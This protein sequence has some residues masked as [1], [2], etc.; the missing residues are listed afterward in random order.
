MKKALSIALILSMVIIVFAGCAPDSP[1][2]S[3]G[4]TSSGASSQPAPS[5]EE[6]S[7]VY[8]L[9]IG[10]AQPETNPRHISLLAFKEMVEDKTNGGIIVEIFPAGQLGNEKEM[11]EAVKM[12]TLQGMRG[13]HFEYLQKALIF[14]LPFLCENAKQVEALMNSDFALEI[15]EPAK[16]HGLIVLGIGD[17]GGFRHFSNNVRQIKNLRTLPV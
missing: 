7:K 14:T 16:E 15:C 17:A 4:Q 13:G 9:Q 1:P 12:G 8:T 5:K 6:P 3:S 2:A 10:H 11:V